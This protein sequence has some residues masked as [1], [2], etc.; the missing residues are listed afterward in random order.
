[1]RRLYDGSP[2]QYWWIN[3]SLSPTPESL[4]ASPSPFPQYQSAITSNRGGG[5]TTFYPVIV[6]GM[7]GGFHV[8]NVPTYSLAVAHLQ[9]ELRPLSSLH[10]Q[11]SRSQFALQCIELVCNDKFM[12]ICTQSTF[13]LLPPQPLLPPLLHYPHPQPL[14]PL[15]LPLLPLLPLIHLHLLEFLLLSLNLTNL[16]KLPT[17]SPAPQKPTTARKAKKGHVQAIKNRLS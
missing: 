1:M 4:F 9:W 12:L 11:Y 13:L 10:S 16:W 3:A 2:I 5:G 14:P 15:L 17:P 6:G 8:Q 7:H